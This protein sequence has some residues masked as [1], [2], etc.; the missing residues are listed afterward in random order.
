MLSIFGSG[1]VGLAA[2]SLLGLLVKVVTWRIRARDVREHRERLAL[3][4]SE[5]ERAAIASNPPPALPD[6]LVRILVF[7]LGAGLLGGAAPLAL[8]ASR[9]LE[10]RIVVANSAGPSGL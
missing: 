5:A 6:A 2:L 8:Q 9:Q 1:G 4:A 7:A 10:A 3:A